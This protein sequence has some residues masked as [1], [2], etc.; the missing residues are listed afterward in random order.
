MEYIVISSYFLFIFIFAFLFKT[1]EKYKELQRKIIHIGMGPLVPIAKYL[2]ITQTIAEIFTGLIILLILLNYKF[3]L[4]PVIEDIER[5]SYGTFFY[6]LSLF[7][8]IFIFWDI[9]YYALIAGVFVMTFGDGLAGLIGKSFKSKNWTIFNQKKSIIGTSTMFLVSL[10]V[11]SIL[12]YKNNVDFNY[13]YFGIAL[14]ATLLEQ[15]SII[16][17]DN[18]SVPIITSTIFH[19]LITN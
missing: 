19:L 1:K 3:K 9:N 15:I 6:C 14:I 18:F 11:I 4:V 16:G 13:Y 7:I 5:K 2:Q 12:G 17:I 10:V 8:L